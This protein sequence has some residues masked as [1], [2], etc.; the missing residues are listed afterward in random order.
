MAKA[1]VV[2]C[3]G[4]NRHRCKLP[5]AWPHR[6]GFVNRRRS[7]IQVAVLVRISS[8]ALRCTVQCYSMRICPLWLA[9]FTEYSQCSWKLPLCSL[10]TVLCN[11]HCAPLKL[12]RTT[13]PSVRRAT[14][15]AETRQSKLQRSLS[16]Q[17]DH[18]VRH[19]AA[20]RCIVKQWELANSCGLQCSSARTGP[21]VL[22][23]NASQQLQQPSKLS[24]VQYLPQQQTSQ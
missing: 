8:A 4:S 22:R 2:P 19:C 3:A 15:A 20:Q 9:L 16:H 5:R 21:H 12:I 1:T 18:G 6:D 14:I 7:S 13:G 11:P 17:I 24:T 10:S 23:M